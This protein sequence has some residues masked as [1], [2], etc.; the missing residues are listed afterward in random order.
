MK[1]GVLILG[2]LL[3]GSLLYSQ[4]KADVQLSVNLADFQSISLNESQKQVDVDL[5]TVNDFKNG[6]SS[7]RE[8]HIEVTSTSKYEV[9]VSASSELIGESASIPVKT[10]S[11]TPSLGDSGNENSELSFLNVALSTTNQTIIR[12]NTGDINRSFNIAYHVAGGEEYMQKP[13]GAYKT[14]LTYT[15][16]PD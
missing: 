3:M 15:I 12:S 14:T 11:L 13:E 10:V 16:L 7:E 5:K 1:K 4:Q 9:K 6:K 2:S 8:N